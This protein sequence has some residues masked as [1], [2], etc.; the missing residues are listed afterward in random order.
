MQQTLKWLLAGC[1]TLLLSAC[2]NHK[3]QLDL[4][5]SDHTLLIYIMG[6]NNLSSQADPNILACQQGMLNAANP[7]NVVIYKDNYGRNGRQQYEPSLFYLHSARNGLF[8]DTVYMQ[9]W[10][11]DVDSSDPRHLS[12]VIRKV[13]RTF[14]TPVKGLEI[15]GHGRSWIPGKNWKEGHPSSRAALYA[16]VDSTHTLELWELR[17][18]LDDAGV[19]FDYMMFDACFMGTAEVAYELRHNC[20]W[21]VGS[22]CELPDKGFP[23]RDVIYHLSQ[24]NSPEEGVEGQTVRQ[25]LTDCVRSF[26]KSYDKSALSLFDESQIEGLHDA[27]RQMCAAQAA[28]LSQLG[29]DPYRFDELMTH[30]GRSVSGDRFHFYDLQDFARAIGGDL[31][32]EIEKA[33]PFHYLAKRY[34]DSAGQIDFPNGCGI[35]F[36]PPQMF[37]L[38]DMAAQLN[39]GYQHIEWGR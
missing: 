1:L 14:N 6:D 16:G 7:I 27:F 38:S 34:Y 20:D 31:S 4:S 25:T 22:P 26:M 3:E 33:M 13:F 12:E 30:Y 32:R 15:W 19:H 9:R 8:V 29:D 36:T 24:T 10:D 17:Q 35:S 28:N 5:S 18:A 37:S 21:L 39:E 2:H 23:Y 11:K